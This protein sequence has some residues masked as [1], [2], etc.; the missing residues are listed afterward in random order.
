MNKIKKIKN[1]EEGEDFRSEDGLIISYLVV[2][3]FSK[4]RF[5]AVVVASCS[6]L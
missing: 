3:L 1:K 4:I 6:P 2:E 5:R